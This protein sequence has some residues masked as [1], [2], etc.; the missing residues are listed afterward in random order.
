VTHKNQVRISISALLVSVTGLALATHGWYAMASASYVNAVTGVWLALAK[1]LTEGVF[2]RAIVSEAGYGGTRYFPL[3]FVSIATLMRAGIGPLAAGFTIS[4]V[5]AALLFL[6][7]VR[8]T[9]GLGV[10]RG[11][12]IILAMIALVPQFIQ[13]TL[14]AIR[15][16][17]LAAALNVWGLAFTLPAFEDE[18]RSSSRSLVVAAVFFTL[19]LATKVTSLFAPAAA[20]SAL[21]LSRRPRAAGRLLWLVAGGGA[22]L[23]LALDLSSHG[24]ALE[25]LRTCA[26]GGATVSDWLGGVWTAVR[27]QLIGPSRLLTAVLF[28]ATLAWLA[29]LRHG[30][31]SLPFLLFLVAVGAAAVTL[32]APGTIYVNQLTEVHVASLVLLGWFLQRRASLRAIGYVA[33]L[34]LMLA[35]AGQNLMSM[36]KLDLRAAARTLPAERQEL[37]EEVER[38]RR[39]VLSEAPELAVLAGTRP[40]VLDPFALR[41]VTLKRSDVLGDLLEKLDARMFAYVLLVEDPQS[42]R[43]RGWYGNVHFGWPVVERVMANYE[44]AKTKAGIRV[45]VPRSRDAS[46]S[47]L[48]SQPSLSARAAVQPMEPRR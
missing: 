47:A 32:A 37:I 26:L 41:V 22:L 43:G 21:A 35:G 27:S 19:A 23:V 16:D 48:G 8:L 25:S 40:Y 10:P 17:I 29:S 13:Q 9:S 38:F 20:I 5:A 6:G 18:R 30:W 11:S 15:S 33:L 2:Y 46:S 31:N 4:L 14:F 28:A 12:A 24:R 36:E 45:Y 3:F 42:P 34:A 1:D 7:V 39:P 44:Y